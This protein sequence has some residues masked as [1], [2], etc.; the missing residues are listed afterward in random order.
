[1]TDAGEARSTALEIGFPLV[2]KIVSPDV[3]H[4][5]EYGLIRLNLR[6]ADEV[7]SAFAE[8][9]NKARS[10]PGVRIEGAILEPMLAGGVEIL[11]GASRDPVF[12]WC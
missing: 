12:G 5:T 3:A 7:A 2:M 10:L 1:V 11:A 8:M 9:A 4:K 6:S